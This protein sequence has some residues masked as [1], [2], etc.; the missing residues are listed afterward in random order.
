MSLAGIVKLTKTQ[1]TDPQDMWSSAFANTTYCGAVWSF[2]L[3]LTI[4]RA[5]PAD[6]FLTR[7]DQAGRRDIPLDNSCLEVYCYPHG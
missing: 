5:G 3:N 2:Y 1:L 6:R 7:A 4:Q